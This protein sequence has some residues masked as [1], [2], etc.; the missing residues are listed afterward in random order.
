MRGVG[1][2]L[3][4]QRGRLERLGVMMEE[5][6]LGEEELVMEYFRRLAVGS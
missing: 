3:R 1:G 4:R 2:M 6:S 5:E